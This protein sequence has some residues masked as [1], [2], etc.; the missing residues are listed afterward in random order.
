MLALQLYTWEGEAHF[1]ERVP[2]I[3]L[4]QT[5][6]TETPL[7]AALSPTMLLDLGTR[8]GALPVGDPGDLVRS[9][10]AYMRALAVIP[11]DPEIEARVDAAVRAR[12]AGTA[13]SRPLRRKP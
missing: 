3:R 4:A 13:A 1:V 12:V 9:A 11:I 7:P 6:D 5:V 10:S 2:Q 8:A